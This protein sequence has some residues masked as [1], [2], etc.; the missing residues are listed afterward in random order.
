MTDPSALILTQALAGAAV[1]AVF[2]GLGSYLGGKRELALY[3][4]GL[5]GAAVIYVGFAAWGGGREHLGVEALGVAL[6]TLVVVTGVKWWPPLLA[7]GWA[8]HAAWDLARHTQGE[9]AY[10]PGWYPAACSGFDLVVAAYLGWF[11]WRRAASARR[12]APQGP[13]RAAGR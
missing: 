5:A 7:I 6:F 9:V 11:L 2:V 10:V 4:L 12:L 1:G 8:G 13:R 3:A